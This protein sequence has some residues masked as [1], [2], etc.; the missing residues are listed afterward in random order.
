MAY[1]AESPYVHWICPEERG[2]LSISDIHF[3]KKLKKTVRRAPYDI[4][5]NTDFSGVIASCAENTADRPETW[6][7]D[8]I[9]DVF[10]KLHKQG[11]AHSVEAWL[12]DELVGGLYGLAI[13][14][15]FFGESM[16]SRARDAS[17][18]C[19]VHLVARL[20]KGRFTLLDTQFVNDH[21]K[22]FG[23][24]EVPHETYKLQLDSALK[25]TGDFA[26][27]DYNLSESDLVDAYFKMRQEI[28]G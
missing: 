18:I 16:F 25:E 28:Q 24:Y 3:S 21:L 12:D 27:T 13:G 14:G 9:C 26:L 1:N 11:H 5:I 23:V 19:L 6:I 4:R 20:W 7:N 10:I 2:Q 17:K 22:Q 8:S 15:A